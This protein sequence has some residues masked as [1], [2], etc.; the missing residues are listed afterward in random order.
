MIYVESLK[1]LPDRITL[2]SND[3]LQLNSGNYLVSSKLGEG[4]H[5][6]VFRI[7]TIDESS[8]KVYALKLT[9]LW[10]LHPEEY[11]N[12]THRAKTEFKVGQVDS[13]NVVRSFSFGFIQG[14]PYLIMEYCSNGNLVSNLDKFRNS[15]DYN[16]FAHSL[17]SGLHA[18]HLN[19]IIHRD[20]KPE[21]ILFDDKYY[22]K[23][24]D[25]GISAILNNRL[26][27]VNF[28]GKAKEQYGTILFAPPE[29]LNESK[30]YKYTLPSMDIYAFGLTMYYLI[31][32][33]KNPFGD[34]ESVEESKIYKDKKKKGIATPLTHYNFSVEKRWIDLIEKCTKKDPG[35]RFQSCQE[36]M[37]FLEMDAFA[38]PKPVTTQYFSSNALKVVYGEEHGKVYKLDDI[39]DEKNNKLITV[40]RINDGSEINDIELNESHTRYISRKHATLERHLDKW[41]LRDGQY[42]QKKKIWKSSLNGTLLNSELLKDSKKPMELRQGDTLGIGEYKLKFYAKI[43]Q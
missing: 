40:G 1:S 34:F 33:G 14:N 36:I 12:L 41:F 7:K 20:I 24:T 6:S 15:H 9:N 31:S 8:E 23:L 35:D 17:L 28:F 2:D 10:K 37:S 39:L 38:M 27:E 5:G 43:N 4:G 16:N 11:K 29:Q 42:D 13:E 21:N 19:G 30:Y 32:G 25:F 3:E 22:L 26:T 18:L